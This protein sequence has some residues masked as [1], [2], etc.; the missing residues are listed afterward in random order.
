MIQ[1]I[2]E[3]L[4]QD[5]M[6]DDYFFKNKCLETA[7]HDIKALLLKEL[8]EKME[9]KYR[10]LFGNGEHDKSPMSCEFNK[11]LSEAIEVMKLVLT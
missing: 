10:Y 11:G 1:S 8:V 5:Y 2:L 6:S 4:L 7:S 3:K 9:G